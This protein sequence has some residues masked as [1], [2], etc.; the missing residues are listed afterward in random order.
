M[1]SVTQWDCHRA[2]LKQQAGE[3]MPVGGR[4]VSKV[5]AV[6]SN[7]IGERGGSKLNLIFT[8]FFLGAMVFIAVKMV[9][10]YFAN[11]QFQDSIESESR[12]ALTGYPKKS[13]D[14]IR[15]DLWKKTQELG[16]PAKK[17]DIRVVVQNGSVDLALDYSV[18]IDLT[19]YQ[20]TLKFHPHAD[21]H[22][23]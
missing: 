7:R 9:P 5:G 6:D 12:F 14:D 11:Y 20:F 23:I 2:S 17:E 19:V 16:I 10:V 8:L 22:T 13:S 4:T 3:G 15:E 1:F 18:P 21:N